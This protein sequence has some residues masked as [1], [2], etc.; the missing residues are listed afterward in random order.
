MF[1]FF[2]V[3]CVLS[4]CIRNLWVA[5]GGASQRYIEYV[6]SVECVLSI[7]V[8]NLWV[9]TGGGDLK[10]G[11]HLCCGITYLYIQ[12]GSGSSF[13]LLLPMEIIDMD[14]ETAFGGAAGGLGQSQAPLSTS[15][16]DNDAKKLSMG[17]ERR[18]GGLVEGGR[19]EE[20]KKGRP[21]SGR[22]LAHIRELEALR[23]Q[24]RNM[25]EGEG[26]EGGMAESS[27][28]GFDK[29]KAIAESQTSSFVGSLKDAILTSL[30]QGNRRYHSAVN[31]YWVHQSLLCGNFI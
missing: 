14:T 1:A 8:K 6:F 22:P 3:E 5:T 10:V 18:E 2:L 21:T 19:E 27:I 29:D 23:S 20:R 25:K 7:Y 31:P 13:I 16:E 9:A 4:I 11:Y 30:E 15:L 24:L 28:L 12:V 26:G 17:A